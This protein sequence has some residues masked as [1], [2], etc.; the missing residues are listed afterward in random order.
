MV[1]LAFS[2]VILFSRIFD[3]NPS[4]SK[5]NL[6]HLLSTSVFSLVAAIEL[7]GP[8]QRTAVTILSNIAY[9]LALVALAGVVYLVRDWRQLALATS[10]PFLSF[11]LY[12]W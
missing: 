5:P 7:V 4:T 9:S 2:R 1:R 11:F 12:W 3:N 8:A 10:V 6:N